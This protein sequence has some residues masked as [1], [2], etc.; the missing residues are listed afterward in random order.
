MT[1]SITF[2]RD[3]YL[4]IRTESRPTVVLTMLTMGPSGV[5]RRFPEH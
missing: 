4:V 2:G 1:R 3:G 5:R